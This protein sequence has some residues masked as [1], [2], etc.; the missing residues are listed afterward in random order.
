MVDRVKRELL[1]GLLAY[2]LKNLDFVYIKVGSL[3]LRY[4]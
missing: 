3:A 2:Q 4:G 1:H